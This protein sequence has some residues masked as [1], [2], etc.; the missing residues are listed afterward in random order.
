MNFL[1]VWEL[2]FV[3]IFL[4]VVIDILLSF[5]WF[6]LYWLCLLVFIII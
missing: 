4:V 6:L 3:I 2:V 1:M 5:C